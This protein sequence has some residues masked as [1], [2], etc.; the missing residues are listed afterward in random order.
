VAANQQNRSRV[1]PVESDKRS[2][3]GVNAPACS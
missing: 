1:E 2:R 3:N